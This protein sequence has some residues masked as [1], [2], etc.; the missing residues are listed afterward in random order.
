M[1]AIRLPNNAFKANAGTDV[2]SDIIFLQKREHPIDIEPDWVYLGQTED[3]F[4]I[5]SYFV[6]NPNMVL[7]KLISHSTQ[8]GKEECTVMPKDGADLSEQLQEAIKNIK[9]EYV[10]AEIAE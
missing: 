2:V 8:Y 4:V 6:D 7:G 3:G 10:E 5:N 1:G 9:G